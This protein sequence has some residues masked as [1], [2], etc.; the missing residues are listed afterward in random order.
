MIR[1]LMQLR[2][3]SRHGVEQRST[4]SRKA[5]ADAAD[6][7]KRVP[8]EG[9]VKVLKG[10]LD[11]DDSLFELWKRARIEELAADLDVQLPNLDDSGA[12]SGGALPATVGSWSGKGLN[13]DRREFFAGAAVTPAAAAALALAEAASRAMS[14]RPAEWTLTQLEEAATTIAERYWS[15]PHEVLLPALTSR[16]EQA[17]RI[18]QATR[19][20]DVQHRANLI[21]GKYAYYIAR[22]GYHGGNREMTAGFATVAEQYAEITGDA[23]LTGYVAGLRSCVAFCGGRFGEAADYA[24][25]ALHAPEVDRYVKPR[26]A[27]Y[28]ACTLAAAGDKDK[29]RAAL[30]VMWET[31]RTKLNLKPGVGPWDD[32]NDLIFSSLVLA[33]IGETGEARSRASDAIAGLRHRYSYE[34]QALVQ[35]ALGRALADNDPA[36]AAAAGIT[37]LTM[38]KIWPATLVVVRA[39]RLHKHLAANHNAVPEV[40]ELGRAVDTARNDH[41]SDL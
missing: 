21:A 36:D 41:E 31:G 14:A 19:Q 28:L 23:L 29:A 35:L 2:G 6:P 37:A 3:V 38:N 24:G 33:D 17:E 22:L 1:E 34:A 8:S 39:G 18:A 9:T 16:Y 25:R 40:I 12:G 27:A 5:V 15:T 26:L 10:V 20:L 30:D 13:R 4:L 32:E 11:A 7:R